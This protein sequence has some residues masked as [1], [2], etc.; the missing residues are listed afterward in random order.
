MNIFMDTP[1][2]SVLMTAYNREKYIGA[3]IDSVLAQT[4]ENWELI[5]TND[6]SKD[7]TLEIAQ[8]YA[9]N[10][11]RIRVYTNE[12]NLGDY[13]NRN[14]AA[15]Y[16]KGKYLKYLD[17]DD[18]MY[19]WALDSMVGMM[20]QYPQAKIGYC[21]R[22]LATIQYN[23]ILL[24]PEQAYI[25]HYFENGIPIFSRSPL[26]VIMDRASF[27]DLKGFTGQQH[28]GDFEFWNMMSREYPSLIMPAGQT[29]YRVH[30]DQQMNDN[31]T[32]PIVPFKYLVKTIELI[33][34]PHCPLS[35]QDRKLIINYTNHSMVTGLLRVLS[36]FKFQKFVE[37]I[38]M[39]PHKPVWSLVKYLPRQPKKR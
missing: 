15:S 13:P 26:S 31:R 36:H 32:D 33:N 11:S 14:R 10:D 37:M 7:R 27:E 9:A 17:S 21:C 12:R 35:L 25:S 6:C 1:K 2:V 30:S 22:E 8:S 20:E 39:V 18:L 28:L 34:H 3:A 24:T 4:Y 16:A 29:W 38:K 5:I 23:P 19:P